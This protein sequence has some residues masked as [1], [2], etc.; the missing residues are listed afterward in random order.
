[1]MPKDLPLAVFI[2]IATVAVAV[3]DRMTKGRLRTKRWAL[4]TFTVALIIAAIY[5]LLSY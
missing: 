3:A 2:I 4:A 5:V 1:M